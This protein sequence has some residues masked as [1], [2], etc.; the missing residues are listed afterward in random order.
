MTFDFNATIA[1][2]A[3]QTDMTKAQAGGG[4]E[5]TP[6]AA[7]PCR[8]RLVGYIELGKQNEKFQGKEREREKVRLVFELSGKN[9]QPKEIDGKKYPHLIEVTE[10]LSLNE[11]ANFFKL[12]QRLNYSQEFKHFAQLLGRSF[13][14]EVVH[15]E[16][17]INGQKRVAAELKRKGEGYTIKPPRIQDPETDEW[18]IVEAGPQLTPTRCFLWSYADM[19]QWNSIFIEGEYEERKDEKT[20]KVIAPAKSKNKYQLLIRGANNFDGSPIDV[21][22]KSKGVK[23]DLP[24]PGE[25]VDDEPPADDD[26]PAPTPAAKGADAL[27]GAGKPTKPARGPAA[28]FD[29]DIPF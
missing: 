29:D 18:R 6:P 12:F 16:Y 13:L 9:H 11:K 8:L 26:T 10:T 23:L 24:K 27:A 5:Y 20:G 21:L 19:D 7:G 22:L 4:G 25:T 17:E 14:G 1:K 15:R 3:E 28:D 2:A